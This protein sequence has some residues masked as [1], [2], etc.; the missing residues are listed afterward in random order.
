MKILN[1]VLVLWLCYGNYVSF[2]SV[3]FSFDFGVGF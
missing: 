1:G 2:S 3:L